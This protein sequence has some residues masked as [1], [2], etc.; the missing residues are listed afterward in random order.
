MFEWEIRPTTDRSIYHH[1]AICG[2]VA[3]ALHVGPC[4]R[5]AESHEAIHKWSAANG[6]TF[7]GKSWEIYGDWIEDATKLETRIEY[8]LS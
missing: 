2:R 1:P 5:R 3:S 7:A 6:E 4:D 8:Q